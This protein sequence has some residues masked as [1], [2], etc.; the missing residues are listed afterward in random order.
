MWQQTLMYS[1]NDTSASVLLEHWKLSGTTGGEI[2]HTFVWGC[3]C[4]FCRYLLVHSL[5]AVPFHLCFVVLTT[6]FPASLRAAADLN[7]HTGLLSFISV[8]RAQI[9]VSQ[10]YAWLS[11]EIKGPAV[12]RKACFCYWSVEYSPKLVSAHWV[13]IKYVKIIFYWAFVGRAYIK[14][15]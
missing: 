1:V 5:K 7:L 4:S 15:C 11:I 2:L 13:K 8:Q 9:A 3:W 6:S 10:V 12:V 14:R